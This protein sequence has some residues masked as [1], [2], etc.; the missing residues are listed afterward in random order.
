MPP[1]TLFQLAAKSLAEE[2]HKEKIP[3]DFP[4]DTKSSNAVFRELLELNPRNIKKLRT[5]Y[6]QLSSLRQLDSKKCDIYEEDVMNLRKFNLISLEIGN[7]YIKLPKEFQ[8]ID[9]VSLLKRAVN[10]N[11]RKMMIHLGFSGKEEFISGWEEQVFNERCQFSNFCNWFPNLRVLD[12]SWARGLSTLEGI[13]NLKNLQVLMIRNVVIR[14]TGGYKELS[15]LKNLRHLDVSCESERYGSFD[16]MII[17]ECLLESEV[18]IENLEFLDCSMTFVK[19][20]ELRRFVKNHPKLK[21]VVAISTACARISIPAIDLLNFNSTHSISKSLK[22]A[23]SN[24]RDELVKNCIDVIFRK[25]DIN[26]EQLNDLEISKFLNALCYVL[27][28]AKCKSVKYLVIYCFARSNFFQTERFFTS[29]SLEILGI[30]ELIFKSLKNVEYISVQLNA[31]PLILSFFYRIV[32]F[33]RFGRILQDGL[34]S[35]I[36]EKT[37]ELSYANREHVFLKIL[38]KASRFMS[39]DQYKSMCENTKVMKAL[40]AIAHK[41]IKQNSPAYQ[42]IIEIIVSYMNQASEN[43]L[44]F[45]VTNCQAVEKCIDQ[46]LMLS[47]LPTKD[48]QKH[49]LHFLM[50]FSSVMSDEQLR[51][52]YGGE[53][54]IRLVGVINTV[55]LRN[56]FEKTRALMLFSTL[57]LLLTKNLTEHREFIKM[58]IKEVS[59]SWSQSNLLDYHKMSAKILNALITSKDSTDESICSFLIF[60]SAFI[61]CE[62]YETNGCWNFMETPSEI[63]FENFPIREVFETVRTWRSMHGS[64]FCIKQDGSKMNRWFNQF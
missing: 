29:Y 10:S 50:V 39:V 1:P 46:I 61:Y 58:K 62:G 5:H 18:R 2:I 6:H 19:D 30:V 33:L 45:L 9:I 38:T 15:E 11:S 59:K 60:V 32:N 24:D 13:K 3:L 44:K 42:Q 23:L 37:V 64:Q 20:H 17:F 52:C 4:L 35:L 63:Y 28:E 57:Y 54:I 40:F 26:H 16:R 14:G 31:H 55:G 53:T 48:S 8:R 12:I 41:L 22:Y 34:L 36:M 25:L 56:S 7:Y 43:T 21:T 27:R 49:L 47:E 51:K